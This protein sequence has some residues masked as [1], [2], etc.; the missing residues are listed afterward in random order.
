MIWLG[1]KW[2]SS[3]IV[4]CFEKGGILKEQQKSTLL[5][6]NDHFKDLQNQI[7]KLGDFY[8]PRT[9]AE[10]IIW[11]NKNLVNEIISLTDKKLIE[12]VMSDLLCWGQFVPK[13]VMF[14][15][16][17]KCCV[18][19]STKVQRTYSGNLRGRYC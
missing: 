15:M 10:D 6:D 14:G 1:K 8:H 18:C 19:Y 12:E 13:V 7:K 11:A 16:H 2:K 17:C 3:T 9:T 5:D 4:D